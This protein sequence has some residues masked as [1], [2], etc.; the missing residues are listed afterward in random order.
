[1]DMTLPG[2]IPGARV[3]NPI[4]G[5]R[6]RLL[7]VINQRNVELQ[8]MPAKVKA[9]VALL[10]AASREFVKISAV[11][12]ATTVKGKKIFAALAVTEKRPE[13]LEMSSIVASIRNAFFESW[14]PNQCNLNL[15][16]WLI[17]DICIYC[18]V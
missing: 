2:S 14:L 15:K 7:V 4:P 10:C 3:V 8:A 5:F 18:L 17:V 12:K 9:N 13:K 16:R 6:A 11:L 1:M